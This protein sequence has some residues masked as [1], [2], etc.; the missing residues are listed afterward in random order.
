MQPRPGSAAGQ[1]WLPA[2]DVTLEERWSGDLSDLRVGEPVT[3]SLTVTGAG[4][5]D[6]QLPTLAVPTVPGLRIYEDGVD[7]DQSV[8]T[9]GVTSTRTTRWAMVPEKAGALRLPELQVT[10]YDTATGSTRQARLPPTTLDVLPAPTRTDGSTPRTPETDADDGRTGTGADADTPV[11]EG[12]D[13]APSTGVGGWV[14]W[15]DCTGAIT[16]RVRLVD[17]AHRW[18]DA[19]RGA[20]RPVVVAPTLRV[21]AAQ[22]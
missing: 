19:G 7:S 16:R 1:W 12:A 10:W 6:A 17:R 3:R 21:R 8:T 2:S 20:V 5:S 13:P 14:G 18:R 9:D 15:Q 4:V 11:G 22:V